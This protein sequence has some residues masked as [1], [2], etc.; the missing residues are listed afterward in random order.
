MGEAGW[1]WHFGTVFVFC[2]VTNFSERLVIDGLA[3]I[4]YTLKQNNMFII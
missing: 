3:V 4:F 1:G 2:S